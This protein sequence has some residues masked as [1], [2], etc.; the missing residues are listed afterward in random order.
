MS[1]LRRR[2]MSRTAHRA[3]GRAASY[4]MTATSYHSLPPAF[5][6][7]RQRP[8]RLRVVHYAGRQ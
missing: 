4:K 1:M 5:S 3:D 6:A 2:V 8:R 7:A